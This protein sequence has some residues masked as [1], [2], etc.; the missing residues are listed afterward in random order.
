MGDCREVLHILADN[1]TTRKFYVEE[2]ILEQQLSLRAGYS[3]KGPYT[4]LIDERKYY[5]DQSLDDYILESLLVLV[6][7]NVKSYVLP[8]FLFLSKPP[9]LVNYKKSIQLHDEVY[10]LM[11]R[12][13]YSGFH[14]WCHYLDYKTN[15]VMKI[16][17]L[18]Q[19]NVIKARKSLDGSHRETSMV[20]YVKSSVLHNHL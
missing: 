18:S 2:S 7:K 17:N 13:D 14:Y 9:F 6:P 5:T 19:D 11:G 8:N 4:R 15:T 20:L 12:I 10:H 16:D 3:Y 1:T